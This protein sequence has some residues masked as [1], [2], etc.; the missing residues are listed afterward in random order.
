MAHGKLTSIET[1]VAAHVDED[2]EM[3]AWAEDAEVGAARGNGAR[4]KR[5]HACFAV[6][7]AGA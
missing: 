7:G 6:H 1:W 4:W 3:R 5:R 2:F